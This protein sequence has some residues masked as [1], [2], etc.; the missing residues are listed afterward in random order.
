MAREFDV[1]DG[2]GPGLD[3]RPHIERTP[4]GYWRAKAYRCP[5][6]VG[7]TPLA[8]FEDWAR[9]NPEL[10]ARQRAHIAAKEAAVAMTGGGMRNGKLLR[11][12]R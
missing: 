1:E 8:A 5:Q 4:F 11:A 9:L 12:A 10:A 7:P 2:L 3:C 6:G